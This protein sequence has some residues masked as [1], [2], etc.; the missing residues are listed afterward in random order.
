[1]KI[2]RKYRCAENYNQRQNPETWIDYFI[3]SNLSQSGYAYTTTFSKEDNS[4]WSHLT[5]NCSRY[6]GS[7]VKYSL[8]DDETGSVLTGFQDMT[9]DCVDLSGL[10][11]LGAD[12][13]RVKFELTYSEIPPALNWIRVFTSA[14]I[15][16][17]HFI[18]NEIG[19]WV[20][21]SGHIIRFN[22]FESSSEYG[23]YLKEE[24]P[25]PVWDEPID[26][27]VSGNDFNGDHFGLFV[28][29]TSCSFSFNELTDNDVAFR[30]QNASIDMN[31]DIISGNGHKLF[32]ND[33]LVDSTDV[34]ISGSVLDI[35][36]WR[37]RVV[38]RRLV[39]SGDTVNDLKC[40]M[41]EAM[42][43]DTRCYLFLDHDLDQS[44][45]VYGNWTYGIS[46]GGDDESEYQSVNFYDPDDNLI[47]SDNTENLYHV[48][49]H[50]SEWKITSSG[51][52][53]MT[54]TRVRIG[55]KND[56]YL[57][58]IGPQSASVT[59]GY[60]SDGDSI[61]DIAERNE[62]KY[63]FESRYI[64]E[65]EK[66]NNSGAFQLKT[67]DQF[68]V[69]VDVHLSE[70]N[71]LDRQFSIA[72]KARY[73][74]GSSGQGFRVVLNSNVSGSP[75]ESFKVD[76]LFRWYQTSWFS[77]TNSHF[78]G[79]IDDLNGGEEVE[80]E[81][82]IVLTKR[83]DIS[84]NPPVLSSPLDPDM[85]D[86][87]LPDGYERTPFGFYQEAEHSTL[88]NAVII[89]NITAVNSKYVKNN[90]NNNNF[91]S[92][93]IQSDETTDYYLYIRARDEGGSSRGRFRLSE[94]GG[95]S[96][97]SPL[98]NDSFEWYTFRTTLSSGSHVLDLNAY[99]SNSA[100]GI[101]RF[102]VQKVSDIEIH[103][104]QSQIPTW[105]IARSACLTFTT[106]SA[107]RTFSNPSLGS[108]LNLDVYGNMTVYSGNGN[109]R[110]YN[111]STGT[112]YDIDT[113]GTVNSDHPSVSMGEMTFQDTNGQ[114]G[115]GDI[116]YCDLRT[117]PGNIDPVKV[118]TVD[119]TDHQGRN[120]AISDGTL[121]WLSTDAG[122]DNYLGVRLTDSWHFIEI[123][124]EQYYDMEDEFGVY[125]RS[126]AWISHYDDQ[127]TEK[128]HIRFAQLGIFADIQSGHSDDVGLTPYII[129][130][131]TTSDSFEQVD[132]YGHRIVYIETNDYDQSRI[133]VYDH[134]TET[135]TQIYPVSGFSSSILDD[136]PVLI[137]GDMVCWMESVGADYLIKVTEIG[138]SN[139]VTAYQGLT[140]VDSYSMFGGRL[141]YH[142]AGDTSIKGHYADISF[143]VDVTDFYRSEEISTAERTTVD[144]SSELNDY[145]HS[146]QVEPESVQSV[147]DKVTVGYPTSSDLGSVT[148]TGISISIDG[149]TDPFCRDMDGDYLDDGY[150]M[151]N[152][153][154]QSLFETEDS[155]DFKEWI[156]PG[157]GDEHPTMSGLAEK[158]YT[159][160]PM[161]SP[162]G[163]DLMTGDYIYGED[164]ATGDK[165]WVNTSSYLEY[166]LDDMVESG[167]TYRIESER[168]DRIIT[169][170][171]EFDDFNFDNMRPC[172]STIGGEGDLFG[173]TGPGDIKQED[174]RLNDTELQYI[175]QVLDSII[176]V[177]FS[178]S[179]DQAVRVLMESKDFSFIWISIGRFL[180]SPGDYYSDDSNDMIM[181]AVQLEYSA[182]VSFGGPQD[183]K[184]EIRAD[185]DILPDELDPILKDELG[186]RSLVPEGFPVDRFHFIR[187]MN[188]DRFV[189]RD[190]SLSPMDF[191][192]DK[193]GLGDMIELINDT[194]PLSDD[195][196]RDG[197]SDY[198]ETMIYG[199]SAILRDTDRD[200]IRDAVELGIS[201][202][203]LSHYESVGSY[204]ER[205][206]RNNDYFDLSLISN[207]DADISDPN[208][209]NTDP[210]DPD[211]DHDGLPDGWVDGWRYFG[212]YS[213]GYTG[214]YYSYKNWKGGFDYDNMIQVYEGEDLNLDGGMDGSVTSW[215]FDGITHEFRGDGNAET[216][217]ISPNSDD[218]DMPDGFEVWYS[219]QEPYTNNGGT[220]ILD[221]TVDD[222]SLDLDPDGYESFF[223]TD[224]KSPLDYE[225]VSSSIP[226]I[227]QEITAPTS[228]MYLIAWIGV[229]VLSGDTVNC[230]QIWTGDSSGPQ[231]K[232]HTVYN[233]EEK[234][235]GASTDEFI[236]KVP[237]GIF[238][239][240]LSQGMKFF[241]SVPYINA[242]IGWV[243]SQDA[244]KYTFR[245]QSGSWSS[246]S[247][248]DLMFT[249]YRYKLSSDGLTNNEEYIVGTHPKKRNT[250]IDKWGDW[251]D[252]L[253]DGV[254]VKNYRENG[255]QILAR[256][257]VEN[258]A[259][260][261]E[262]FYSGADTGSYI[263]F[264]EN[265]LGSGY[266]FYEYDFLDKGNE[267]TFT[268][269]D[270]RVAFSLRDGSRVT[271]TEEGT[272]KYLI[273]WNDPYLDVDSYWE[274][275][276]NIKHMNCE[277]IRFER[278]ALVT[279][280]SFQVDIDYRGQDIYFSDPCRFDTDADGLMDGDEI[281][282]N[283]NS[284]GSYTGDELTDLGTDIICNVR[285]LDSDN[286]GIMDGEEVNFDDVNTGQGL[287]S[288][289][290]RENMID[291][292]SDG[293]G[294]W[295]GW[296]SEYGSDIDS[297]GLIN[298]LD[299]DSDNDGLCDGWADKYI[300]NPYNKQFVQIGASDKIYN[301]YNSQHDD[302]FDP[303]EGED[304][305]LNG[306]IDTGE[307]DPYFPDSDQ[308]GLYDG[309][310]YITE[311][312]IVH[313]GEIYEKGNTAFDTLMNI[314]GFDYNRYYEPDTSS[315]EQDGDTDP[316]KS[317]SDGDD[318]E[319]GLEVNG[320][321]ILIKKR[322]ADTS[323]IHI[324]YISD[325]MSDP[326]ND[327]YDNDGLDDG[328]E[329]ESNSL[330]YDSDT[331]DDGLSDYIEVIKWNTDPGNFDSDF[332]FLPDG[333][334]DG[335]RR[336]GIDT[337]DTDGSTG[338]IDI[339]EGEDIDGDGVQ[340]STE[341]DPTKKSSDADLI[342]DGYEYFYY[343]ISCVIDPSATVPGTSNYYYDYDG[344][345][346]PNALDT[347]S[348]GDGIDDDY[349]D[350]DID[351]ELDATFSGGQ[352]PNYNTAKESNPLDH[353]SE[354]D[355]LEDG[356]D[357]KW[358]G[359]QYTRADPDGDGR[360]A[361]MDDD[362]DGDGVYDYTELKVNDPPTNP[363]SYGDQDNDGDG[364]T[365]NQEQDLGLNDNDDD[366]DND[367]LKDGEEVNEYNTDPKDEDSDNDDIKDGDEVNT[368]GSNPNL[369]DTDF[370]GLKDGLENSN[371][372]DGLDP[373]D[374]DVDD[375]GL[376]D[377]NPF[378]GVMNFD[379]T[380]MDKSKWLNS[381]EALEAELGQSKTF[382][383][384]DA[385][386][387]GDGLKDGYELGVLISNTITGVIGDSKKKTIDGDTDNDREI[388]IGEDWKNLDP[389]NKD[390]DGDN[391]PD[392]WIDG[393]TI[394]PEGKWDFNKNNINK[395]KDF[396]EGEGI[397][398]HHTD[399]VINNYQKIVK[400][401]TKVDSDGD[402]LP[403]WL[404]RLNNFD[405]D[406]SDTDKDGYDDGN[407]LEPLL[408][409]DVNFAV[410]LRS[411]SIMDGNI[412]MKKSTG[413]R[414]GT[415][416]G[417]IVGGI[418]G[419]AVGGSIGGIVGYFVGGAI[420]ESYEM[421]DVYIKLEKKSRVTYGDEWVSENSFYQNH[422]QY[423]FIIKMYDKDDLS[424]DDQ[425]DI[426]P[427]SGKDLKIFFD[428][429][430]GFWAIWKDMSDEKLNDESYLQNKSNLLEGI[431]VYDKAGG[432]YEVIREDANT[433]VGDGI[434]YVSGYEPGK[435]KDFKRCGGIQFEIIP[436]FEMISTPITSPLNNHDDFDYDGLCT[437]SEIFWQKN[438]YNSLSSIKWDS[439]GDHVSDGWEIRYGYKP[440]DQSDM[441]GNVKDDDGDGIDSFHE[442]SLED[443][444]SKITINRRY[445]FKGSE[446]SIYIDYYQNSMFLW[447][448]QPD[449]Q[450]IFVEV[451]WMKNCKMS[452]KAIYYV[453]RAFY[454]ACKY[455][456][457]I[458]LHIDDGCMGGGG[459]LNDYE[460]EIECST[461]GYEMNN[462]L[463]NSGLDGTRTT[464]NRGFNKAS[465]DDC[466]HYCL[467]AD[468]YKSKELIKGTTGMGR[469]PGNVF[470][471]FDGVILGGA[472]GQA[473]WFMHELGHNLLGDDPSHLDGD[474]HCDKITLGWAS[475]LMC[476]NRLNN[477]VEYCDECWN[478]MDLA[479]SF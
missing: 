220:L 148:V 449:R 147:E 95:S 276:S 412:D 37:S 69:P 261:F 282:W 149:T 122:G 109:T 117:D 476:T 236:F 356:E 440:N 227:A 106:T 59:F 32:I 264:N 436:F 448:A 229:T 166:D 275:D 382:N 297:D 383:F 93:N 430:S 468:S 359:I 213:Y 22:S 333:H 130:V 174:Y 47:L 470:M 184:F 394:K 398:F 334:I 424:Q 294:I 405:P 291:P 340:D 464:G 299:P 292:D 469:T 272:S 365:Y 255:G 119:G 157:C 246:V 388:D 121:V 224:Q 289:D 64:V 268:D 86:D 203:S 267:Y 34:T 153:Y 432:G 53:Y 8:I 371:T 97:N 290:S 385:D 240:G 226:N 262:S 159:T 300:W 55:E 366:Y 2:T 380:L 434:G 324:T 33:S 215:D 129:S 349:E 437:F 214:S 323:G 369:P 81:K 140:N 15:S 82:F 298:G 193:D 231:S 415:T 311:D 384:N 209:V 363:L 75:T 94:Q 154:N 475:C 379:M 378:E 4:T 51:S 407:D 347:D 284:D 38:F 463:A 141:Y 1:L 187:V 127:S 29:N 305:N 314:E 170:Y 256:T 439:D 460:K 70:S 165:L 445:N 158:V 391:I 212:E 390:T 302:I 191:D 79:Y 328:K 26:F 309:Y 304:R 167:R 321:S 221:P 250:D 73:F 17:N 67:G 66:L 74:S 417:L 461:F 372:A 235:E 335:W 393:W 25:G 462:L 131:D 45:V 124:E 89:E 420:A 414:I 46:I 83:S 361:S 169:S 54:P 128:D 320:W 176:V 80:V 451:D 5:I 102:L 49:G 423:I 348:D 273:V 471:N 162:Q 344:T 234:V 241:V 357:V 360:I 301:P 354:D 269:W 326:T 132:I 362:S 338:G 36:L 6:Y 400:L 444:P 396:Y 23:L 219:T 332:D 373:L 431:Y 7:D 194:Y 39:C 137:W 322:Y 319:D 155:E 10:N 452:D 186:N 442:F 419:G 433:G 411:Y 427:T 99:I 313:R 168:N 107:S 111:L 199:T 175:K 68:I 339:W 307:T 41:S 125:T 330:P 367:G 172:M 418:A 222:G 202:S 206:A 152:Y 312:D 185:L 479:G 409:K 52:E 56:F 223:N 116:Y 101:D 103:S 260:S 24:R 453:E 243:K 422:Y 308:D 134:A 331:D 228:N 395:I 278:D 173:P 315:S 271:Y 428:V 151:L 98:L 413:Q 404:E 91:I 60:D 401:G 197:I 44:S 150:E 474:G 192:T 96:F 416:V 467:F 277:F 254:E 110:G 239:N 72:V 27:V 189:I 9:D 355:G 188:L 358:N 257:N 345:G 351:G 63:I 392:G 295:D 108:S 205:K 204:Y 381:D 225:T 139:I 447:G 144:F 238:Y 114:N 435:T 408:R 248:V 146:L 266:T 402:T 190:R 317:D 42:F 48:T 465:R 459:S 296:E 283:K 327:D 456:K 341:S 71:I 171:S 11:E 90:I 274:D 216:S 65:S 397:D 179:S 446:K 441:K 145:L 196:D 245:Y 182:E 118:S 19:L 218:D 454:R 161:F 287:D 120:P 318:L 88:S 233:Y 40:N 346:G 457:Y 57:N 14:D 370:D 85:D 142:L 78:E 426:S 12:S 329:Y 364:L 104:L 353:D 472:K 285:D 20:N 249:L 280:G 143:S 180:D 376:E 76:H 210:L 337:W 100:I 455:N 136:R 177:N 112:T 211:T 181:L 164:D 352:Y 343:N 217:P 293:D 123:K 336:T 288:S 195:P 386:S 410:V 135:A 35:E 207:L 50:V 377:G 178:G 232:L 183:F 244:S 30:F 259:L 265:P 450:D 281:D 458:T 18:E 350:W 375:D 208:P 105:G 374:S 21:D 133:L 270:S 478:S 115:N 201:N 438:F 263:K 399:F 156:E 425:I 443:N 406:C 306:I 279:S 286:D 237:Q 16:S 13:F 403:D 421:A 251:D 138:S 429:R 368:V 77:V 230:I 466:F 342:I 316:L 242:S 84:E 62:G 253:T 252:G 163:S 92:F 325:I 3:L 477:P 303:W 200:S 258:G 126:V 28:E 160:S 61:A 247:S 473:S 310:D 113:D 58:M 389:L 31:N 43:I 198:N 87:D 387:D